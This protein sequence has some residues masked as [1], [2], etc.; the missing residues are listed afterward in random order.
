M[1]IVIT[2]AGGQLGEDI[3]RL[4]TRTR[5]WRVSGYQRKDWDLTN[6]GKTL[7]VIGT[8][9]PDAVIHCAAFTDVDRC[10]TF[11]REAFRVNARATRD[12]AAACQRHGAKLIYIST[13]YVFDGKKT[14]GYTEEDLPS[15]INAYGK[16]KWIGEQWVKRLCS[17]HLI[18]RTA[19][20]YGN[21]GRNFVSAIL[22][23]AEKGEPL[24]VVDD[25]V[26]CPT[27]TVDLAEQVRN[28]L[29]TSLTGVIH[30]AGSGRCSWYEFAA[31]ILKRAGF[32]GNRLERIS[33]R[34]LKREA[35]RPDVSV[36]RSIRLEE[37][38]LE[39]LPH[40][41]EGLNRYFM[42]REEGKDDDRRRCL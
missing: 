32:R 19:W 15:P 26:G 14:T 16:T 40:W 6:A 24:S 7:Q 30:T 41:K 4:L 25:Q 37:N 42:D 29:E 17:D 2:G 39:R 34:Q 18:L 13:D 28:L 3:L 31:S 10:E 20:V 1:N 27:Y 33:S 23:K 8:E 21:Y 9:Q 11:P 12:L 35:V 36:L 5:N 22:R 38:G